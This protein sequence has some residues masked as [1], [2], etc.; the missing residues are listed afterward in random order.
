[1][2]VL[3]KL[4]GVYRQAAFGLKVRAATGPTPPT[5]EINLYAD[6]TTKRLYSVD[7]AGVRSDYATGGAAGDVI[8]PAAATD[9]A[10][11][12]FDGVT[13]KLIQN[14]LITLSDLGVFSPAIFTTPAISDFVF[15]N[16]NH[17]GASP[18]GGQLS[19]ALALTSL[20]WT[21]S[22]HTGTASRIAAFD[23]GGAASFLQVGVDV[24]AF[25]ANL[26]ALSV[27]P[28]TGIMCQIGAATYAT[29]SMVAPAAGLTI[30]NPG[31]VAGA[32]TF[33]LANDLSALEAMAG[34][35][36]VARTAAETYAQRTI[37]AGSTK[38]TVTN[39]DGIAGN[40]TID[41]NAG[42]PVGWGNASVAATTTTRYLSP[43]FDPATASTTRVP[44]VANVAG[45]INRLFIL[46][47]T[48]AG[49]G[50]AIVYTVRKNAVAQ[51][52]TVS[53][54]STSSSGSD[55]ANTFACAAGDV[56][57][58][59]VTKAASVGTSPSNIA[60]TFRFTPS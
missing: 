34:T 24:Q 9:N 46:H 54:A 36:L 20:G 27:L 56:I 22:G 21:A 41:I 37:T 10:I 7:D 30:A 51:T 19:H 18:G 12:R 11:T 32:P 50:A 14:S 44:W 29:R 23:G 47:D 49:N 55:V 26:A 25:H 31:G 8:G 13:G 45:N 57:D 17:Q 52:L 28:G 53:L 42:V 16:H 4:M 58:I 39:G 40:P 1:M 60:A 48:P 15:A 59:E 38:V 2:S 35:G 5:Q 6:S 43:G 33:A 3:G